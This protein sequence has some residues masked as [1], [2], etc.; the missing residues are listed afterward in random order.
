MCLVLWKPE[1]CIRSP[2]TGITGGCEPLSMDA[3]DRYLGSL[4]SSRHSASL[5]QPSNPR[6]RVLTSLEVLG[7]LKSKD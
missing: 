3:D 5:S 1:D 2:R 7:A 4:K 6:P